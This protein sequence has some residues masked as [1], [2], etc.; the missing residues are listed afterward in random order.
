MEA[1]VWHN[2]NKNKVKKIKFCFAQKN[3]EYR[4]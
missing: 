1:I 3:C 2:N 4:G